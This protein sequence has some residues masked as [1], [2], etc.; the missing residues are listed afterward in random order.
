MCW[1]VNHITDTYEHS[2]ISDDEKRPL[3]NS[4]LAPR[5][6]IFFSPL[7]YVR[8]HLLYTYHIYKLSILLCV[9]CQF[10]S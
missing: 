10:V 3:T 1:T 6:P 5:Y 2:T 8:L 4:Y 9:I 7:C